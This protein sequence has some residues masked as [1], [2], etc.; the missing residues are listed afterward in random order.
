MKIRVDKMKTAMIF[1]LIM[2]LAISL[3]GADIALADNNVLTELE[4]Q[5]LKILK[6]SKVVEEQ[7]SNIKLKED[8]ESYKIG[9][10]LY[11]QSDY[12]QAISELQKVKYSTL[13][14]P[15]YIKSQFILGDCYRKIEDWDGAI[16]VYK[17]LVINDP[18]LTDY[19][20]F[21]L[22]ETYRLK[23]ENRES[24][25]TY[26]R[27]I[28][29]FPQRLIIS[30]ANYQIAQNYRELKDINSALIYYK[31]ILEDSKDNQL[32][33]KVL[34]ELSE[35]YW[36][37]KKY[38]DSLNCLYEILDEGYRLKRNSEPEELLIRYL[39]KIQEDL[40][41][42][43]APYHIMVKCADILFKYRQYNLAEDLYKEV[44]ETFPEA[45][46]IAEVYYKRAR[47]LYY[48]KEYKEAA[49]QCEEIIV[50]FPPSEITIKANYLG[51]NSLLASGERYF[52]LDKYKKIIEQ[53]PET[54][55]ARESYLRMAECY[56][57]LGEP[58]KGISLWRELIS[59]Y[60][61]SDQAMTT[62]W[63]LG[64]YYTK[65]NKDPEAL[66][67]YRALSERFSKSRL[68]DDALYWRGKT[69]Q[70]M[71]L[72]DEANSIY[73]KLLKDYPLSYYAERII[74]QR[75][76]VNYRWLLPVVSISKEKDFTNLEGFLDKYDKINEKGQ[77]FLLKA[78]LFG[79][80]SFY[81]EAIIELKGAL[82]Y[83]P[84]NIFLLFR[85]SDLYQKNEDYYDSLNHSEI[86]FNY[87]QDNYP[88]EEL[89]LELWEHLYPAY[90]ED[91]I[92]EY[93]LKYEIDP[94]LALAMIREES[95]FN[96]WN[97]SVAGARGLMQIIFSTGEWIAQKLNFEDFNDEMLFS[98]EVNINLGCWY[99]GYL[100]ERFLNDPILI[101]SGYNAG[102]GTTSKW[103]EQYDRSDLDNFVE[104]VPYSE[105]REHIKKVM[106]SYQ[107]YKRLAQVLSEE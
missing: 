35:I 21:F 58:E 62:W 19:S 22:A 77:L 69:L 51:G 80:V 27:I 16:E 41:D 81:K 20:L 55:Y 30:E 63:N 96:A 57:Q 38:I 68:G 71:G 4:A 60:P 59:K 11:Q 89:P 6:L 78:E 94:L 1:F 101:I 3:F 52:A 24:T 28:E 88:L 84:G 98:P 5:Q 56:F 31:N 7:P 102:P 53:Y 72:E 54:Y 40:K 61:N 74:E 15:L 43:K 86:I 82:N 32:K 76:D 70:K 49:N 75:E 42:I 14:L 34:L 95:R 105:T 93:A 12:Q 29:N 104:N 45:L 90:F 85:L 2:I 92:R 36:Q 44:I 106:K 66:E 100:K 64:R 65:N 97:E 8:I 9:L 73:E 46:D 83:N 47:T 91:M 33:A 10:E 87:L 50:K 79:E 37:E 39:Y 107:M 18:I 17:N 103:L 26:K 99:I 23:G 67:A 48:K 25:A 13:N